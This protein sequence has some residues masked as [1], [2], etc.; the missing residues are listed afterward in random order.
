M[1]RFWLIFWILLLFLQVLAIW[2]MRDARD[3]RDPLHGMDLSAMIDLG[4]QTLEAWQRVL[5][6]GSSPGDRGDSQTGIGLPDREERMLS[7]RDLEAGLVSRGLDIT[8]AGDLGAW[9]SAP[10][11]GSSSSLTLYAE[12]AYITS[13]HEM[14]AFLSAA[15]EAIDLRRAALHPG[16][17]SAYPSL[18][19]E[20]KG[21]AAEMGSLLLGSMER[22]PDWR[23]GEID[24]S[25]TGPEA[26]WWMRGSLLYGEWVGP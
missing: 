10:K 13:L 26:E 7:L 8:V 6:T 15:P 24:L 14:L 1:R 16:P 5:E 11:T 9:L 18:A 4:E 25:T 23:I 12:H 22:F 21:R 3:D 19:F 17:G 20:G 2:M